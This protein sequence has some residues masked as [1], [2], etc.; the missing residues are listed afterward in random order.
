M[1]FCDEAKKKTISARLKRRMVMAE[2]RKQRK[3]FL[4]AYE[5]ENK[6]ISEREGER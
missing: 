5:T 1:M 4:R 6:Q 2:I 3:R